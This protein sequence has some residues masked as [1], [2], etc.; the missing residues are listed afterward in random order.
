MA[1]P[2]ILTCTPAGEL[3]N[4]Y[5][6][7]D[8]ADAM[9][10][11]T[12]KEQ[13]WMAAS[14]EQRAK[15]LI[16]ATSRLDSLGGSRDPESADR[17]LFYGSPYTSTQALFFPRAEDTD[18]LIPTDVEEATLAQAFWQL[19]QIKRPPLVNRERLR[20]EGVTSRSI[21]GLSETYTAVLRPDRIAPEAW[22]VMRKYI[23]RAGSTDL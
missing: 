21:D 8:T 18:G 12:E 14:V 1:T 20:Q 2:V 3:D 22:A 15:M 6:V 17:P 19:E 23:K 4:S 5:L 10:E 11:Y 7:L 9:V 13:L 16:D